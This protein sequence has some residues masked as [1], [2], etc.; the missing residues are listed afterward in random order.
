MWLKWEYVYT[1]KVNTLS[2]LNP[3]K[4][5]FWVLNKVCIFAIVVHQNALR[6]MY[7]LDVASRGF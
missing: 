4:A 6:R 2:P 3:T 1:K 7:L 5:P